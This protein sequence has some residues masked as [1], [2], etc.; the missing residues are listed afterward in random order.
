ME[1]SEKVRQSTGETA[2]P[3][4]NRFVQGP[5]F[6]ALAPTFKK[7]GKVVYPSVCGKERF[8]RLSG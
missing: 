4:K 6:N 2:Q 1:S 3:G 7:P 5:E 8:L